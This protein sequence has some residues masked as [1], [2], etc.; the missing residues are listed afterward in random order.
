MPPTCRLCSPKPAVEPRTKALISPGGRSG[1]K[2][3]ATCWLGS[4]KWATGHR[5]ALPMAHAGNQVLEGPLPAGSVCLSWQQLQWLLEAH[6]P[7]QLDP[8]AT[9]GWWSPGNS[10][11]WPCCLTGTLNMLHSARS[12]PLHTQ[13]NPTS[14]FPPHCP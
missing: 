9:T 6:A 7:M 12:L 3:P 2:T 8:R 11:P 10:S 14:G 1:P 4:P 5:I 13:V